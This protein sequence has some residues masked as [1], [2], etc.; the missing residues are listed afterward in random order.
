MPRCDRL[1]ACVRAFHL[2]RRRGRPSVAPEMEGPQGALHAQPLHH[3]RDAG[4]RARAHRC[5]PKL[6]GL[7]GRCL[8]ILAD[9]PGTSAEVR[10]YPAPLAK[11]L[12]TP[13][14]SFAASTPTG[15]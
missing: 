7:P 14:R 12:L 10:Q 15:K 13:P 6:T 1:P 3:P 5:M 8:W 9:Y 11:A 4:V 2:A